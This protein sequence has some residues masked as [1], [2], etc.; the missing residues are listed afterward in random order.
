[1]NKKKLLLAGGSYAD[2]PMILSAKKL[3]YHVITSGFNAHDLGHQHSDEFALEDYSNKE[4][5]LSLAKKINI[6][7]ICSSCNDF[8][9]LS[10]AYVAEKLNLPGHDPYETARIIHHKDLYRKFAKENNITTPQARSYSDIGTAVESI[11]TT[12]YPV[13]V[14][15]IDMTGGKGISVA[16]NI[17]EEKNSIEKAFLRSKAKRIVI[18]N[19]LEGSRHGFSSFIQNGKVV[20]CFADNEYYYSNP[21]LVSG[22]STPGTITKSV[23]EKL[24][25]ETE[26]IAYKLSL[27]TGIFHIQ[28]IL[29]DGVPTI[30]EICRR[31]PG[32]LYVKLV[33]YAM[34]ID[35]PS[36]IVKSSAGIKIDFPKQVEYKGF[37]TR[38]CIM[39][40]RPGRVERISYDN[41]IK[42]NMIENFKLGNAGDII[43]DHLITKLGI[44]FL[45]FGSQQEM[46]EKTIKMQ[47]LIKVIV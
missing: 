19:Y 36:W 41:S 3:G 38:H 17:E 7:A 27:K 6:S 15:P 33:E 44:V 22:A 45:K 35:Y 16:Y 1:M 12:Q 32:D 43:K 37:F 8:S 42:S 10:S 26:I 23:E 9:A 47:E 13:I 2:I 24:I 28:F 11:E 29:K 20:F 18:E 25:I 31:A 5:M 39:S 21:Y 46:I 40:D 14:K 30:I 4:A 34:G